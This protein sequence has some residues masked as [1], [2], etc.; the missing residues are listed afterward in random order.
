M[1]I[2]DRRLILKDDNFRRHLESELKALQKTSHPHIM[3]VFEMVQ[4]D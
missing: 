1:K 4:D 3:S 2:I